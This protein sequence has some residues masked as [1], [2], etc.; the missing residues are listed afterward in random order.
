MP[1][2]EKKKDKYKAPRMG[3]KTGYKPARWVM[4]ET[5]DESLLEEMQET[6]AATIFA[7]TYPDLLDYEDLGQRNK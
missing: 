2:K 4:A 3:D 7:E 1:E 5:Y 6:M